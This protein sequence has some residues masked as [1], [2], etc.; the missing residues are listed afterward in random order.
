[1]NTESY[2]EHSLVPCCQKGTFWPLS[3]VQLYTECS[4]HSSS[5]LSKMKVCGGVV[6]WNRV[7]KET[8][9]VRQPLE[10]K[11]PECVNGYRVNTGVHV[12]VACVFVVRAV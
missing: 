8:C 12:F 2:T 9:M 10:T 1:M 5:L 11:G 7:M 4:G 3:L 6:N